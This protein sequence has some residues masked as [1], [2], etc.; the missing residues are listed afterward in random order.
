M[1]SLTQIV[2][3][4]AVGEAVLGKKVGNKALLWGAVAGTIPDLD[5]LSKL[6]VD[7]LTANEWHRGISHSLFFSLIMAPILAWAVSR[8]ERIFLYLIIASLAVFLLSLSQSFITIGSVLLIGALLVWAV[9]KM[10]L[11]NTMSTQEDWTRL[12][13]WSL[14]THPLLDAHTSWGTQLLWPLPWKYSWN[15]IFVLDPLY[16]VPFMLFLIVILFLKRE[17]TW[18]S[19]LNWMGIGLSSLYMMFTL[20]MKYVAFSA[21]QDDLQARGQKYVNMSTRPA[22]L[23]CILWTANVDLGDAYLISYFSIFDTQPI[24]WVRVEKDHYLL[25]DLAT[26]PEVERLYHLTAGEY[27]ITMRDDTLV[28]NDLRFGM[29]GEPKEGGEF[30]FAYQLIPEGDKLVVKEIPPPRPEGEKGKEM[31]IQLWNRVKGN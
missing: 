17:N 22:P 6:F 2:L 16:T 14:F 21:F 31:M 29:M 8:K 4:A 18:R 7:D 28:Y 20:F 27:A 9:L 23:N 15:N 10:N 25:G 19:T 26:S 3:G 5:V 24:H 1:D 13:F 11:S 12:M 30:V